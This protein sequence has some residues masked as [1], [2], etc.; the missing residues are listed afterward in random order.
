MNHIT[1]NPTR[2]A[3]LADDT[4][5]A[6]RARTMASQLN[7][8][9]DAGE[10]KRLTDFQRC[11][12]RE[13]VFGLTALADDVDARVDAA[14]VRVDAALV[15]YRRLLLDVT[16]SKRRVNWLAVWCFTVA[17]GLAGLWWLA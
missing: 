7:A 2:R 17:A 1:T 13:L 9:L 3:I 16:A 14:L 6:E 15:E 4:P 5:P 10:Y 12:L 11:E 8:M